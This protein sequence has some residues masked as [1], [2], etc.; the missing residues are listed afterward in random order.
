MVAEWR[1]NGLGVDA[2]IWGVLSIGVTDGVTVR[3]YKLKRLGLHI[4]GFWG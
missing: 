2:L 4:R 3:G 1:L